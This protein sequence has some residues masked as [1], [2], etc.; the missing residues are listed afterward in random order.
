MNIRG[1]SEATLD[2][3]IRLGALKTYQ[4]LYHLDRYRDEIIALEGFGE[5]SYENLIASI[6]E[7][8]STPLYASL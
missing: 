5:K 4:D 3:L 1:L 6:N 8:R 7:S 2:Q